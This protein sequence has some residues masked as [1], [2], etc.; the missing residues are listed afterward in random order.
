MDS[1]FLATCIWWDNGFGW[2]IPLPFLVRAGFVH[3]RLALQVLHWLDG[4][5]S[6]PALAA[7]AASDDL[8][9][10]QRAEVAGGPSARRA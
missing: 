7:R 4:Q 5:D 9:V 8:A 1:L 3:H 10:L 6:A 2:D